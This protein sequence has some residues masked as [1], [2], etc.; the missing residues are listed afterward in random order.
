MCAFASEVKFFVSSISLGL[1]FFFEVGSGRVAQIGLRLTILLPQHP[2]HYVHGSHPTCVLFWWV[3]FF[4]SIWSV[5]MF[6][7]IV[8]LGFELKACVW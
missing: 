8:V 5:C 7:G 1:G 3:S 4:N 6:W 2:Q